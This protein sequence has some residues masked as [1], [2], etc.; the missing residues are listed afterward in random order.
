MVFSVHLIA[1]VAPVCLKFQHDPLFATVLLQGIFATFKAYPS[2]ADPGLFVN[3]IAIFPEVF[4]CTFSSPSTT[5]LSLTRERPDMRHPLVT[6]MLHLYSSLLLVLFHNLW[7]VQGTGNANFY[8]AS[9]MVFGLANGFAVT[10]LIWAALRAAFG[11]VPDGY[12]V[13]QT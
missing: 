13:T 3:T 8:Y 10:D 9:T 4:P 5:R 1:Y 6:T 11:H 2:L 12:E 7:L